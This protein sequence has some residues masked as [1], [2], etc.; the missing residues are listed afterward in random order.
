MTNP[1]ERYYTPI[2]IARQFRV[3][4]RT[5]YNWLKDPNHPLNGSKMGTEWRVSASQLKT[6]VESWSKQ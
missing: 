5:V 3:H 2:E 4:K 1:E 6:F